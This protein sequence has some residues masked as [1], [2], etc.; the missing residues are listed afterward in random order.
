MRL[1]FDRG[2]L[3]LDDPPPGLALDELPGVLWD[4]RVGAHRCPA[5]F[6]ARLQRALAARG[7]H[8][9]DARPIGGRFALDARLPLRAYQSAALAAWEL[10]DRRGVLVLPT[11]SGKTRV[12]LA[13]VAALGQ[14]TLVL[15][16]T[17]V[18]IT[19]W[20]R[21][22]RDKLGVDPGVYG[23]GAQHVRAITVATFES[24]WR[25]MAE[26][27]QRF[28]L[29]I[30]DEAHHFGAGL[31]DEALEMCMAGLRLGLT[32]TPPRER[33]RLNDLVGPV[34][35]ELAVGDLT[36]PFLAPLDAAVIRVELTAAERDQYDALD[37]IFRDVHAQF[38]FFHPTAGWDYFVRDAS[39]TDRGRHALAAWRRSRALLDF[40]AGKQAALTR[41]LARH[42][43]DRTLVFTGDNATA[44]RI[45]RDH[46]I[47]PITCDI[48]R[49]EREAALARFRDGSLRALV[50]AQVLNEGIDVPDADVGIVV[51]GRGGEREHVQRV[52]RI[53]R[54]GPGKRATLYEL[55]VERTR[56]ERTSARRRRAL[57]S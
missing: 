39:K 4:S 52:G 9:P 36:G 53:L 23:D 20:V 33:E 54:P 35:F 11:G 6:R 32:A 41:L 22:I 30:V 27:G 17:R 51:S 24:G 1:L 44:Y 47:M 21:E 2:T 46:L 12:A 38:R 28:E 55:V 49:K 26:L 57:A 29:L 34:V 13:A 25:H 10:A 18:L 40:P 37:G 3:L 19:Q 7:V 8:C 15:V 43:E 16:P 56:E 42:R 50:S 5:H 14:P 45:A 48:G 31:R